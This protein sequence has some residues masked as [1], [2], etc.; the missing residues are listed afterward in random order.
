MQAHWFQTLTENAIMANSSKSVEHIVEG[1][2][3]GEEGWFH[4]YVY[5]TN[6]DS[7]EKAAGIASL[8]CIL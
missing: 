3:V 2:G 7:V 6:F 1:G 5:D 4:R 8:L